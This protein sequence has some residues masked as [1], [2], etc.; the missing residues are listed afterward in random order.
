MAL[1]IGEFSRATHLS[2]KTLRHHH[3]VGLLEPESINPH[4]GYRHYSQAQIPVAQII[5]RLRDLA[6]PVAVVAAPDAAAR[7]ELIAAHLDRLEGDL[8]RTREAVSSLRRLLSPP[9][10]PLAAEHRSAPP[11]PAIAVRAVVDRGDI[12]PTSPRTS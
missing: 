11:T 9:G 3:D 6:M 10:S 1:T 5:R 8:A 7:N 4:T 2:V 12:L